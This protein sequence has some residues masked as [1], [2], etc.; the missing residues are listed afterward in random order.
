[1]Q[2]NGVYRIRHLESN[3]CYIGSSA[4]KRGIPKGLLFDGMRQKII[5]QQFGVDPS[6]ISKIKNNHIWRKSC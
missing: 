5:A 6:V 3:R 4:D 1:M 2:L